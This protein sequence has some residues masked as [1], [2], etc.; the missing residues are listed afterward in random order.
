MVAS[1]CDGACYAGYF[2]GCS[3]YT[4]WH[5]HDGDGVLSEVGDGDCYADLSCEEFG[6]DGGDCEDCSGNCWGNDQGTQCGDGTFECDAADCP[7]ACTGLVIAMFDA[8][9]DGWNGNVLTIG[10]QSFTIDG[11]NDDGSSATGCYTG[12]MDVVVIC[13]G[14]SWQTEVSWSI[15]DADG[16]ELLAGGA[17]YEGC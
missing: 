12:G 1:Y 5:D 3:G 10:D 4:V 6:C 11:V 13:D 2:A 17:Q 14:G 8:Y 16:T 7:E 9:G 15:N